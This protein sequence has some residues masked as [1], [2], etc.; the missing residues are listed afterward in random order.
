MDA[1]VLLPFFNHENREAPPRIQRQVLAVQDIPLVL[2]HIE[3]KKNPSDF[4]SRERNFENDATAADLND[5]EIS[6]ALETHL[7]KTITEREDQ[8]PMA[9]AL[10]KKLTLKDP[11]LQFLKQRILEN[12]FD[13][14]RKDP[15]VKP[16]YGVRHEFSIIDDLVIRGSRRIVL[17]EELHARAVALIHS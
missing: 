10:I 15:R 5:M 14:H 17:P 6:D 1:K 16:Y 13:K 3:G 12:D 4:L 9:L 8:S 2:V 11:V 7:V